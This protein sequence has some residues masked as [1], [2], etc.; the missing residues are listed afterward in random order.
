MTSSFDATEAIEFC[1]KNPDVTAID[2]LIPDNSGILRGKRQP[3]STLPKLFTEGAGFPGSIYA[4]D[5][6]GETIAETGLVWEDGDADRLCLPVPGTLQRTPWLKRPTG[7]I[8]LS[9]YG[10]DGQSFDV[11]PRT[12]LERLVKRLA[13]DGLHPVVAFELEFYLIDSDWGEEDRPRPPLSPNS[14]VRQSTTQVYGMDEL[15]DFDAVLTEIYETALFQGI[16]ADTAVAE[17]APGQFEINMNHVSDPVRAADDALLFKRCV[18]G[19][20]A[21]HKLD[22]TFMAKPY[23]RHAGSGM[24]VHMSLLDDDGNNIFEAADPFGTPA[25]RHAI[26]GLAATMAECMALFAPNA[27]SYRRFQVESYAPTAPTWGV[28]N[29]TA[30]LRV[31]TGPAPARRVE[32]RVPGADANP[33]LVLAAILAGVHHGITNRI[34]P[35]EPI[36]GNGY[37]RT[38]ASLPGTWVQA[39]DAFERS[40]VLKEYFGEKFMHVFLE[41][42]WAERDKFFAYVTPLEYEWYL[43]TA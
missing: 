43:R 32:H 38:A 13:A 25:L 5:I 18:R 7:Q 31:P 39:L 1:R 16:P 28:N 42:K 4:M 26:G 23:P 19:V 22:A 12:I 17:Y 40:A 41:T 24:H 8:L 36:T 14:G 6:T 15:Y 21:K 35:G 37:A 27:N 2:I 29:R 20:A 3:A 33:Y 11:A 9:M 10:A 34:D 30:A